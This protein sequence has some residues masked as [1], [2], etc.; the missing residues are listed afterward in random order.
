M[1]C[2]NCQTITVCVLFAKL[3]LLL[4]HIRETRS[5]EVPYPQDLQDV[6]G[7]WSINLI[8]CAINKHCF[9][10]TSPLDWKHFKHR[11]L[12]PNS[13]WKMQGVTCVCPLVSHTFHFI[14]GV[15][16]WCNLMQISMFTFKCCIAVVLTKS[17]MLF[18]EPCNIYY[19]AQII[20]LSAFNITFLSLQTG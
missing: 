19:K 20:A 13:R 17:S 15:L 2:I 8:T 11:S 16:Q 4:K 5:S 7:A 14:R 10:S 3:K 9:A 12:I 1:T 6:L 18:N